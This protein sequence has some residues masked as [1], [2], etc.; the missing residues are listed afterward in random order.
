MW[1]TLILLVLVDDR[2]HLH[3]TQ[4]IAK[5]FQ[6][7]LKKVVQTQI[8]GFKKKQQQPGCPVLVSQ[9]INVKIILLLDYLSLIIP[10]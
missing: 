1:M 7:I 9:M 2:T 4:E 8:T 10:S 3:K 5:E 6:A